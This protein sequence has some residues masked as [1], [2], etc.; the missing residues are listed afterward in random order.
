MG[1]PEVTGKV[2][3]RPLRDLSY[4]HAC[5]GRT[6]DGGPFREGRGVDAH[7]HKREKDIWEE[8]FFMKNLCPSVFVRGLVIQ[9]RE[10]VVVTDGG[11]AD[12]FKIHALGVAFFHVGCVHGVAVGPDAHFAV[13]RSYHD[14]FAGQV[15]DVL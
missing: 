12:V 14:L 2:M 7:D 9:Y 8:R 1:P 3:R 11:V 15:E 10:A 6:F 4:G 5:V 13:R